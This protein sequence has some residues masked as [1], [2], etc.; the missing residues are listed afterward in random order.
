MKRA[1][2]LLLL[3]VFIFL[4]G[5]GTAPVRKEPEIPAQRP[6]SEHV[7]PNVT[8]AI[9]AYD[10]WEPMNRRLYNFNA[11]FDNVIFLPVVSAYEF[12][13]PVFVQK[14]IT[15]FFNNLT[16]VTNLTNSLLQFKIEK[17]VN[18]FGRICINTTVGLGGLIDVATIN[19][20]IMREDEDFGQT[21]GFYGL[22]PGPYLVLPILGPSNVRDTAGLAV[23]SVV[24]SLMLGQL[25]AELG[26]DDTH[27]DILNYSL[28]AIYAIDKRHNEPFRYFKT[29]SPF[30]YDLIRRLFLIKR[31]FQ[32]DH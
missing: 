30:E 19:D 23:D 16:E 32:I 13:L 14:G 28:T 15:N 2:C 12:V 8:Y 7:E 3:T 20:G 25:I 21:L 27:E 22:G 18:T 4:A 17:A 6:V 31:Q 11:I 26:M 9:D 5:C 24:Y 29:G 1:L 10:P